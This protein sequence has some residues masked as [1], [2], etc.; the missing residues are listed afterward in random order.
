MIGKS[1]LGKLKGRK[2]L[3][4]TWSFMDTFDDDI[5]NISFVL[6]YCKVRRN[7]KIMLFSC[8]LI[9]EISQI[10]SSTLKMF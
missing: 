7:K 9:R 8:I 4:I 6:L 3:P 10:G 2:T 1:V 5:C